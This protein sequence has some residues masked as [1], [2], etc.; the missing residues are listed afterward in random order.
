MV[1]LSTLPAV[2]SGL[3]IEGIA[4]SLADVLLSILSLELIYIRLDGQGDD[5]TEFVRSR[6]SVDREKA[7]A[8]LA[9]A[10]ESGRP[11]SLDSIAD[12]SGDGTLRVAVTRFG[13]GSDSGVVVSASRNP[14]FPTEQDRLLLGVGANQTAIVVQRR[15]AE[16]QLRSQQELLRVTLS[17]IGDA[18]LTTDVEG[19]VTFLNPIAE[20]MTGWTCEDAV[21]QP[22]DVVFQIVNEETRQTVINPINTVLQEGRIVGLANHTIL[23]AKNGSEKPIDDSA[24]PIRD[25]GGGIAGAILVFRDITER[26]QAEAAQRARDARYRM[27]VTATSDVVYLMNADWSV[28]QPLDGHDLVASNSEPIRDWMQKNVPHSEH[29][30]LSDAIKKA[31]STRRT[32]ELEHQVHRPDGSLGWTLSRAVPILDAAG[33]IVEWFGTARDV[34]DQKHAEEVLARVTADSERRRRLYEAIFSGT[35]DFVYVFSLDHRVLYAN[36]SLIAMWGHSLEE[37]IGKTFLEIGY[38]PWHAELHSREIDQ[39]SDTKKSI[40]GEVPFHGTNGQR[41][42][43]YIFVPVLGADGQVESVAGITRDVTDRKD[44]EDELRQLA[45]HLSEADHKKDEFIALLAHELRN[46]LA[47]IRNGL[48]ILGLGGKEET[49]IATQAMMDRQLTHMVRLIDDLLDVS[50]L[51]RN[52]MELRRSQVLL[53]DVIHSAIETVRPLVDEA[54]HELT[55]SMPDRPI[56]LNADPTRM[57]QVLSNLLNNSVKYT[58]SGGQIWLAV[59]RHEGNVM[60]SVR[61][62]GIGIPADSLESVFDMFSQVDRTLERSTGGLGIGLAL[63]KGLVEMHGGTVGVASEGEGQG[64]TFTVTLPITIAP[65]DSTRDVGGADTVA[66]PKQRIL[67]VDDNRDSATTMAMMLK[68]LG[69]EIKTAHDGV[70]AVEVAER[71]RPEIILMDVGMPRL[72]GYEATKRIREQPWGVGITIVALTGWG[73]DDDRA[74]SKIAGCDSH[75]VKPVNLEDLERILD[76]R[77]QES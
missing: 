60:V 17:S 61:D 45:A 44:M 25:G 70:E 22:M 52:K 67:V 75:L 47:P 8:L 14:D 66:L 63:V 35:P 39:I 15:R 74:Q 36:D 72:N 20:A 51:S 27:L 18:I 26:K 49:R 23:I 59:E 69:H 40:R 10:L 76:R 9:P 71:F 55:V 50:R 53:A 54:G 57:S 65:L 24:A 28:M 34:T 6:R 43:D 4:S 58:E 21:G 56:L 46:P 64:S 30:L 62:S 48:K 12:P 19:R 41:I 68:L 38:E 37:T 42:Y 2:W 33:N 7:I 77:R 5:V 32:F 73:Q 31:I 1:S 13:I 11:E 29:Q 16:D 3:G